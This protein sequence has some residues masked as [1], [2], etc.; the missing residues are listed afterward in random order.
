MYKP[1]QSSPRKACILATLI[2]AATVLAA[3]PSAGDYP[4]LPQP[5]PPTGNCYY[6]NV[7]YGAIPPGGD[8]RPVLVF[9]HGY[10]G[11]ASDWWVDV[12]GV[13]V[14]DMYPLA[15]DAGYRTAFVNLNV[16]PKAADCA[17]KRL[18]GQDMMYNGQVLSQ[19]L[20]IIT[21]HY[22]VSQ[23]D[24]VAHSKGGIDAQAAIVWWGAWRHVRNVFTLG[25][26]HQGSLL[27]DVL[28]SPEGA[29]LSLFLKFQRDNATFSLRTDSMQLFR[30]VTDLSTVDDAIHYYSGA[31][32][33]WNTPDTDYA[34]IGAWLQDQPQ[35]G[36]NDGAV[37]VAST[38]L[39]GATP[40]FLQ[41]WNHMEISIGRNA[42]PHIHS[43]LLNAEGLYLKTYLPLIQ[44]SATTDSAPGAEAAVTSAATAAPKSLQ[45][46]FILRGGSLQGPMTEWVPIEPEARAATWMLLTTDEAVTATLSGPNGSTRALKEAPRDE[47]GLFASAHMLGATVRQPT[48]GPWS[49]QLDG[50]PGAGYLLVVGL[51][52]Q[53]HVSL[54]GLPGHPIAPGTA[55][56]FSA[57]SQ[58]TTS[59]AQVDQIQIETR[60]DHLAPGSKPNNLESLTMA[61]GSMASQIFAAEG[62]Y[63]VSIATTGKTAEGWPF[64]RT[65]VWSLPVV[66]AEKL[67]DPRAIL[68]M[69]STR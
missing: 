29:W 28:W 15:Y 1:H 50:P 45:S 34:V 48:P 42:F 25:T 11:L 65:F 44:L 56:Q 27:A 51:D 55:V 22:G 64:E 32:N 67:A 36:D 17:V 23:V 9:V 19:Q 47:R 10:S 58:A 30:L 38:R 68:A 60:A 37:T 4:P 61:Q 54:A 41:P 46:N 18:P 69:L 8:T 20:D 39:T 40:L 52:S 31:G 13:Q 6:D 66:S 5:L 57:L 12:P 62:L 3:A 35:G 7:Y 14:N 16:D 21:Q 53:L 26:P 2:S 24:I 49:V 63:A 43:I 59:S 33:F